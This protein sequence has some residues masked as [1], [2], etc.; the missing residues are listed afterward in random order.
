[1]T[2]QA[3]DHIAAYSALH[4]NK[5][6]PGANARGPLIIF[7]IVREQSEFSE[8]AIQDTLPCCPRL[9]KDVSVA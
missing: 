6:A 7:R 1:V 5:R 9:H 2:T 4:K 3:D 8:D